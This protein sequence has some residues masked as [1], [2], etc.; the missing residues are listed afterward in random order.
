VKRQKLENVQEEKQLTMDMEEMKDV[1]VTVV[2]EVEAAVAKG[3][4][5]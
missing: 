1:E 3:C 5:G 2:A 4:G